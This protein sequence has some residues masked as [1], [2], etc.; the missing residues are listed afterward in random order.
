MR[1]FKIGKFQRLTLYESNSL[2]MPLFSLADWKLL[3]SRTK[4]LICFSSQFNKKIM[5]TSWICTILWNSH[6]GFLWFCCEFWNSQYLTRTVFDWENWWTEESRDAIKGKN[7]SSF[8]SILWLEVL[9]CRDTNNLYIVKQNNFVKGRQL[10]K[11]A[12][13]CAAEEIESLNH[14]IGL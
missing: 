9:L 6:G 7:T 11:T 12:K 5:C 8:P 10:S 1:T 13:D 3:W 4:I 14:E 2:S